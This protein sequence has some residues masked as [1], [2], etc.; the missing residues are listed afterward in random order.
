MSGHAGNQTFIG[1]IKDGL[2]LYLDATA[3]LLSSSYGVAGDN[4]NWYSIAGPNA[5]LINSPTYTSTGVGSGS[6]TVN[7]SAA[8]VPTG[9]PFYKYTNQLSVSWWVRPNGSIGRPGCGQSTDNNDSM[10]SS[11]WLMHGGGNYFIFYVN[12]NGSWRSTNSA[13][14]TNLTWCNIT[15]TINSSQIC[16]YVN[17][18]LSSTS[19]GISSGIYNNPNSIVSLGREPRYNNEF[20]NGNISNLLIY[21]RTLS[22]GEVVTL[23]SGS[24]ARFGL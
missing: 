23:Y 19:T 3:S 15:G 8:I 6:F 2:V 9:A 12:D 14:L 20:F 7:G 1:G 16:I 5:T 22:S 17:G 18:V 24:K 10:V 4:V 21:N 13:V 11:V